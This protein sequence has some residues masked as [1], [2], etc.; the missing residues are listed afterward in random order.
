[1]RRNIIRKIIVHG[2]D[3]AE[4]YVLAGRVSEFHVSVIERKLNQKNLTTEQKVAVIDRIIDS[5]KSREA[6][7]IIK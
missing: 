1:M 4:I 3:E 2:V 6:D 5:L 7:G